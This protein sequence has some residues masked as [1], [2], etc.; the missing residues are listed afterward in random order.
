MLFIMNER[1]QN[2]HDSAKVGENVIFKKCIKKDM[3][4]QEVHI[5]D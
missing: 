4:L 1:G 5:S 2:K 3:N